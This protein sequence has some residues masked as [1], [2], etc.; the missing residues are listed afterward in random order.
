VK[1]LLCSTETINETAPRFEQPNTSEQ[2]ILG[3]IGAVSF[4]IGV[5]DAVFG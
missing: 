2:G 1:K 4:G 3:R 5:A